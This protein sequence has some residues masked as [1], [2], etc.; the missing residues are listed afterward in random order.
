MLV[1]MLVPQVNL[2]VLKLCKPARIV[3]Y[4]KPFIFSRVYKSR[5]AGNIFISKTVRCSVSCKPV[6]TLINSDP[7]KLFV[8]CKTVCFNNV[9]MAK[10]FNSVNYCLVTCTEHPV[11]A[12]HP[13]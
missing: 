7:V 9:S 10:E 13:L 3:N 12:F 5:D 2:L 1:T 4:N 6:S 11:N 8:T